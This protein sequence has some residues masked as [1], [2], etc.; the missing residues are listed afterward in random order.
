VVRA[1]GV[2]QSCHAERDDDSRGETGIMRRG[3]LAGLLGLLVG[4]VWVPAQS[5][6]VLQGHKEVLIV[7]DPASGPAAKDAPLV[8]AQGLG[9]PSLVG[10]DDVF[11][12][13]PPPHDSE[14]V[15]SCGTVWF[16]ADYLVWWMRHAPINAPLVTTGS[17]ADPVPGALGQKNTAVVFGNESVDLGTFSGF[18]LALGFAFG[19]G[20]SVE[21]GYF[22]LESRIAGTSFQSD[23]AGNPVIARPYFDN[24]AGVPAAYLDA[25]PGL[26]TGGATVAI[27]TRM[28]GYE[29]NVARI[30]YQD[31][32]MRFDLLAGFRALELHEELRIIDNVTAL[33][34]GQLTFLGAPADPP[35]SLNIFERF[36]NYNRF[37]GGQIG[38]RFHWLSNGLDLGITGKLALGATAELARVDSATNL[39][40]AGVA[41][42]TN[43]GGIL[44]QPSNAGFPQ[45]CR[46]AC[47]PEIAI[48]LGYWVTPHI[49]LEAGYQFLYWSQVA[50]PGD[51]I[52]TTVNPAQVPRDPRFGNGLGDARPAFQFH[53]S[54]FWAQGFHF[55][56]LF[57][58]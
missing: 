52:D 9:V 3:F 12:S 7:V 33:V 50:R 22:G 5:P 15:P 20:W 25:F 32:S 19:G 21:G 23:A 39:F 37:Y 54:D 14:P 8:A 57:Q 27:V 10:P 11:W 2:R 41:S 55:G 40:T 1:L 31:D 51:E 42:A 44:V 26:L 49:R 45:Q 24:Q 58:Y 34:P 16:N 46:F 43:P 6:V 36:H 56:V 30:A 38:G 18:R 48:D 47:V 53:Q 35:N 28:F 17:P 4:A 13:A 29:A